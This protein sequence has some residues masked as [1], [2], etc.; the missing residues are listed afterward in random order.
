MDSSIIKNHTMIICTDSFTSSDV[1]LLIEMLKNKFNIEGKLKE[2]SQSVFRIYLDKDSFFNL[3]NVVKDS[4]IR[5][6]RSK[7]H[8]S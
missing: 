4:I 5:C 2:T 8:L 3:K 6:M 7:F 1:L